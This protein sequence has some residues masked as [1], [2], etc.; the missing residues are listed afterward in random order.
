VSAPLAPHGRPELSLEGFLDEIASAEVLPGGGYVAAIAVAM[1]A[2]LVAMAARLS[3]DQWPEA[4]GA[5]AQAEALRF[6]GVSLAERNARAY[7][8]AL[9]ALRGD[10]GSESV[11]GESRDDLIADAL[12]RSADV[13]LRI[14][15]AASDVSALAAVVAER[16]EPGVRADVAVAALLSQAAARAAATL[17]EVNLTATPSDPRVAYAR[18]LAGNASSTL[19]RAL[20]SL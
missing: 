1:A 10:E 17:V 5:A 12:D 14:G 20:E 15:E 7:T 8:N 13:P 4:R 19:E 3:R 18:E 16:C 11:G 9:T 2:G 6:R